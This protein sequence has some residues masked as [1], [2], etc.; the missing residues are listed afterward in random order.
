M[1][2]VHK[3]KSINHPACPQVLKWRHTL[4]KMFSTQV[5]PNN[6]ILHMYPNKW[7]LKT[8]VVDDVQYKCPLILLGAMLMSRVARSNGF[9]VFSH[10]FQTPIMLTRALCGTVFLNPQPP[11]PA[12]FPAELNF[13][14]HPR[15]QCMC[16]LLP[17][18]TDFFSELV[19]NVHKYSD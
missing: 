6:I 19:K 13:H 14:S 17:A 15:S 2:A 8:K 5:P 7:I 11:T 16:L 1:N 12:E 3:K 18:P 4:P 9:G 10:M